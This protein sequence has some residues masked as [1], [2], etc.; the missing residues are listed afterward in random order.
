MVRP[1]FIFC[2]TKQLKHQSE[3]REKDKF[4]LKQ[5]LKLSPRKQKT[6]LEEAENPLFCFC[7][8]VSSMYWKDMW[9]L[10]W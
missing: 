10:A 3:M 8:G 2:Q 6:F 9:R 4:M 7:V 5:I 1:Y